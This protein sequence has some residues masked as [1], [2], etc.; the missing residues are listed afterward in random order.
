MLCNRR[1]PTNSLNG[2][3][4]R[5]TQESS[6]C[7]S[8][9]PSE[10]HQGTILAFPLLVRLYRQTGDADHISVRWR[11][12]CMFKL[13]PVRPGL[14]RRRQPKLRPTDPPQVSIVEPCPR[15]RHIFSLTI[16][17][18]FTNAA[19]ARISWLEEII[20][21]RLPDVDL[22]SGPHVEIHRD[23]KAD[24]PEPRG[25]E[26]AASSTSPQTDVQGTVSDSIDHPRRPSLKRPFPNHPANDAENAEA[27]SEQAHTVSMSL[28]MLSLNSDSLQKHY[29]GSSSGL[30][31]TYLI[32]ASPSSNESPSSI[33]D[34][35][36]SRSNW[37]SSEAASDTLNDHHR[38]LLR[39][40]KQVI[41][42]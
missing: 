16:A 23:S 33:A 7:M 11:G 12:A 1:P 31:F 2:D 36:R 21:S 34:G 22:D 25:P 18:S 5:C 6:S 39:F 4:T 35:Q 9:M 38:T 13:C 15:S 30:L 29:I 20:R 42:M 40:L 24:T 27:F 10:T 3:E 28:G 19:R 17:A 41:P 8:P 32:G 26:N 14:P 37:P